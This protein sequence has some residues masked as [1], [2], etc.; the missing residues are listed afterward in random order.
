MANGKTEKEKIR[1]I[2]LQGNP[3]F[4]FTFTFLAHLD[5]T[6]WIRIETSTQHLLHSDT[7]RVLSLCCARFHL[8]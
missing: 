7:R 8:P 2:Q 6:G 3:G 5:S 4:T 1:R